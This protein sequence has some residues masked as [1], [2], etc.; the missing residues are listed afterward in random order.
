MPENIR[1][2][3][4]GAC[5]VRLLRERGFSVPRRVRKALGLKPREILLLYIN[6]GA[7]EHYI[8]VHIS[9]HKRIHIPVDTWRGLGLVAGQ[10]LDVRISLPEA[11]GKA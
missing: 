6:L 8:Y 7:Q 1:I 11:T 5:R 4:P 3:D 9:A 2:V 10:E